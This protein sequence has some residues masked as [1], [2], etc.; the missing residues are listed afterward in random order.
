MSLRPL[1]SIYAT[2]NQNGLFNNCFGCVV[3]KHHEYQLLLLLMLLILP[4][5]IIEILDT[6][7]CNLY[8]YL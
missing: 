8:C 3:G 1:Q 7:A 5:I 6:C 2:Q 4:F